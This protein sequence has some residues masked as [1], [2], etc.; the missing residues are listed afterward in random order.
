MFSK[1]ICKRFDSII[2]KTYLTKYDTAFLLGHLVNEY[3][4]SHVLLDVYKETYS[5]CKNKFIEC[6]YP[7][8]FQCKL[9]FSKFDGLDSATLDIPDITYLQKFLDRSNIII[10]SEMEK[11]IEKERQLAFIIEYQLSIVLKSLAKRRRAVR[12]KT[13]C[14]FVANSVNAAIDLVHANYYNLIDLE[15]SGDQEIPGSIYA[16]T[17]DTISK[18]HS[19][20]DGTER[21]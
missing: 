10:S 18:A 12:L 6:G 7:S 4:L 19:S 13:L 17:D 20:E 15:N 2:K 8:F 21:T 11:Y 5:M 16:A 1:E 9:F 3:D 14:G